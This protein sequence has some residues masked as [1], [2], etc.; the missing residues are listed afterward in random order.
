LDT[1]KCHVLCL[2]GSFF[3]FLISLLF[4]LIKNYAVYS[5]NTV[6]LVVNVLLLNV[7][8][9]FAV[10]DIESFNT[11]LINKNKNDEL[12]KFDIST[13]IGEAVKLARPATIAP[14]VVTGKEPELIV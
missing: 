7:Y 11:P 10:T 1:H 3:L 4:I 14:P 5:I 9:P 13:N 8:V 6:S 2:H 12:L